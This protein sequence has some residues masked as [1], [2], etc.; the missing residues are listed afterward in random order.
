MATSVTDVEVSVIKLT[1]RVKSLEDTV[2]AQSELIVD[3]MA[4]VRD[5]I[6]ELNQTGNE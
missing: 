1:A 5:T 4:I 3:L 6:D 2:A